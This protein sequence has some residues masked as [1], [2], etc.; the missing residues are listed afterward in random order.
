M[1]NT[2]FV[3]GI[4]IIAQYYNDDKYNVSAE[5]D[6]IWFGHFDVVSLRDREVLL[7][8]GWFEDEGSWSCFV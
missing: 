4:N 1:R 5:H 3:E 7:A 2:D 6:Q 8:L